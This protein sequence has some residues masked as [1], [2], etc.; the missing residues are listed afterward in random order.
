MSP[1]DISVPKA[2]RETGECLGSGEAGC[3]SFL[4]EESN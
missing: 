2:E 1:Q 3:V 4:N